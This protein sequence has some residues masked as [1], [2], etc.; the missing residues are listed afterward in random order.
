MTDVDLLAALPKRR[1]YLPLWKQVFCSMCLSRRRCGNGYCGR[2]NHMRK[3][4][5]KKVKTEPEYYESDVLFVDALRGVL[6]LAPINTPERESIRW[7]AWHISDGNRRV[8][9]RGAE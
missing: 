9:V 6:G 2:C 4:K 5:P 3:N 7:T 8:P 1:A